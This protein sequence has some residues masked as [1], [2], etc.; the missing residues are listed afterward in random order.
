ME[1]QEI[2]FLTVFLD[3]SYR[4]FGRNLNPGR[5]DVR[6]I[7]FFFMSSLLYLQIPGTKII[8]PCTKQGP[9]KHGLRTPREEIVFTA[10]P[11]IQSQS[12]ILRYCQSIFYLPHRPNFSDIFDLCLHWV[13]VVRGEKC[14]LELLRAFNGHLKICNYRQATQAL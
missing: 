12:Q 11:K 9:L 4:G 5:L 10:R 6:N 8:T 2:N 7:Y 1:D 3:R 14:Y 13:S